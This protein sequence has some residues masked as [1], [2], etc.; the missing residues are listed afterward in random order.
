MKRGKYGLFLNDPYQ[1]LEFFQNKHRGVIKNIG[2]LGGMVGNCGRDEK[3]KEKIS[4]V[5]IMHH[6]KMRLL[7][8]HGQSKVL[9]IFLFVKKKN[10]REHK[11]I[12]ACYLYFQINYSSSSNH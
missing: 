2:N 10:S 8:F 3:K 6:K 11:R 12:Y 5:N 7:L 4:F 1:S 9:K